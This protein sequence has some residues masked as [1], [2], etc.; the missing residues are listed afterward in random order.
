MDRRDFIK[1]LGLA[2]TSAAAYT[3]CSNYM[4]EALAQSTVVDD[5]LAAGVECEKGSLADIEHVVILMQ[6]NRSFDHYFGTLRGVRGFG[7]PRPMK[8]QDRKSVF[9]QLGWARPVKN[10]AGKW[11]MELDAL[12]D[13]KPDFEFAEL[14]ADGT[15]AYNFTGQTKSGKARKQQWVK[16]YHLPKM[17]VN[18]PEGDIDPNS[19]GTVFLQDPWHG[20]QDGIAAWNAGKN[21]QWMPFRDIVSM[22]HYTQNDIPLYFKL[23]KTFTLCDAYFCSVN[24]P[25]DPNRS[26]FWTGT[27]K[28][29]TSNGFF[30]SKDDDVSDNDPSRADWKS[31][32]EKLEDLGVDWKFYQDGL[33]WTSDPFAGNY[34]DNT[35]EFFRQYRD[36]TTSIYKKNQSVNSVLRTDASKPSQ[37]EQDIIDNKLP[38]VSWIVPAEAFTEHPKYPP[39]FG[40]FYLNEI[41]RAFLGNREVWHKTV[42]IITYD[43]NGGF[44][45]HVLPPVPP[46]TSDNGQTSPGITLAAAGEINSETSIEQA[47]PIGMGPRV[48]TLVISPWSAGGRVCS[49]VFDHTSVIR[50]LDSWLTAKEKQKAYTP[51]SSSISSWRQA[52]A[53]DLTSAFDFDRTK[54]G[55]MDELID[56]IKSERTFAAKVKGNSTGV[57]AFQPEYSHVLA[58]P[59][60][61]K[62]VL[63]K[64][65]KAQCALLPVGYDFQVFFKYG[66]HTDGKTRVEW[67]I[68]NSGPLGASFYV[69]PYSRSDGPWFFSVEGTKVGGT[70]VTLSE[71]SYAQV[72]NGDY[73]HAIHGP[74]GYLFEFAGNT[75]D[76]VQM[77]LPNIVDVK[78]LNDGA[79]IQIVFDEWPTANGKLKLVSAYTGDKAVIENGTASIDVATKDGWYDVSVVDAVNSNSFLRRYAGHL[80][81]G[82]IS[83]SD[84]AIGLQYNETTRV[85]D[86]V[87]A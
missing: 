77:Q 25:T 78:S 84:P 16:P 12:K 29:R 4:S 59:E 73:A 82:K 87:T 1:M 26:Y 22:A 42:F 35:L 47:T 86:P 34:G 52:I 38:A 61:K 75:L 15:P 20:Y 36:R 83:K 55:A 23:A 27:C 5:L 51:A 85:Y 53:G 76:T 14:N 44:F 3:A 54:M 40:E 69:I 57:G 74:N 2:G 18:E 66:T 71:N 50:F 21:D 28:G 10:A 32:P 49:E 45:D 72:A 58:D 37:F 9:D 56:A 13:G 65:D 62:P 33:T 17:T 81:N 11:V 46:L 6:E 39:H 24:G 8:K 31:Y 19:S 70:P 64:Q 63:V 79:T 80:E 60:A 48:P 67:V 7:D 41:L 30:S 68:R 43:E